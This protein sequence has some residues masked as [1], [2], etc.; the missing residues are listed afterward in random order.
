MLDRLIKL[1]SCDVFTFYLNWILPTTPSVSFTVSP[2]LTFFKC[3]TGS[4]APD[5]QIEDFFRRNHNYS[6]YKGC[7]GYTVYDKYPDDPHQSLPINE[8]FPQSCL[9]IQ[10]PVFSLN[11][12]RKRNVR[13]LFSVLGSNFSLGFNVSK[14]CGECHLKGGDCPRYN[15]AKFQCTEQAKHEKLQDGQEVAVKHLYEHN[16]K[17]VRQ[18]VNIQI[19]TFLS[20][21][22]LVTLYGCTS[23]LSRELL[24]VY[25][26]IPNGTVADDL[27]GDQANA[28][29]L[30]WPIRMNIAMETAS[31]L[32]YLHTFDIIHRD[33]KTNN[34]FLDNNFCIKVADFGL[35]RLFPY[36]VTHVSMAPQGTPGYVDLECH[37]CY[38]LTDKSDVY[39][40]G[41]VLVEFISSMPAVDITRHK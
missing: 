6:Y 26:Y 41:V 20:H 23:Y 10:L 1:K 22:N 18:F 40:F 30:T 8:R 34:I 27:H 4:G 7:S 33:I 15:S 13:D 2:N 29:S 11:D 17:R 36:D 21:P 12:S 37:Q 25:E 32:A 38:Q 39:S 24:P 31:A 28:G 9:A 19:L 3:P 35:S 5:K 16:Y 14:E